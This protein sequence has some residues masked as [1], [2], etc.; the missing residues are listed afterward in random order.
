MVFAPEKNNERLCDLQKQEGML[1]NNSAEVV[2]LWAQ[3]S[4]LRLTWNKK[5]VEVRLI[6]RTQGRILYCGLM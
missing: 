4:T 2:Q 6:E 1:C 3:R 5:H